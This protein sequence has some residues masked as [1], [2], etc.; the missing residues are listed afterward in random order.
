MTA[1]RSTRIEKIP[2]K[3]SAISAFYNENPKIAR[4]LA[5]F[6]RPEGTGEA[7]IRLSAA[8]LCSIL[9]VE[10]RAGALSLRSFAQKKE[11]H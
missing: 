9:S 6:L 1:M 4:M 5:H 10:N 11:I 2:P 8:D 7:W 3:Q